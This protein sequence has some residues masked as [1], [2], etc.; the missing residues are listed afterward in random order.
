MTKYQ[1]DITARGKKQTF[2]TE[3]MEDERVI[4][5]RLKGFVDITSSLAGFTLSIK[6][7]EE[8]AKG[9]PDVSPGA[10]GN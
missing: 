2:I 5:N 3:N 6:P 4:K 1:V 9:G 7:I 10:P 8:G